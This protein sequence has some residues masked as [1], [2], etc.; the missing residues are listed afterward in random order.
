MNQ[1]TLNRLLELVGKTGD[2]VVITDPAGDTP[3][4]LMSLDQYEALMNG[5]ETEVKPAQITPKQAKRPSLQVAE[6]I[7]PP[8]SLRGMS[9]FN[10]KKRDIPLWKSPQDA[11][12]PAPTIQT[13]QIQETE[14]E[15]QFYLEPLE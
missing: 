10:G 8:V 11:P 15:E 5:S 3:Y 4:V 13:S 12:K 9:S 2:K 1:D 14:S 7:D 6:D